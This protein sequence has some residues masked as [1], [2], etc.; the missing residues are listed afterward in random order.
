MEKVFY[1]P[2]ESGIYMSVLFK[3][4][5]FY[6]SL[7]LLSIASFISVCRGI[8]KCTGF[9]PNLT[10][11]DINISGKKICGILTECSLEG[12]SG[13]V[14]YSI[15]GIG[16]NANNSFFP[17]NI[18]DKTTSLKLELGK[19]VKRTELIGEIINEMEKL[20]CGR[21]YISERKNI[22]EEYIKR[23]SLLNKKVEIKFPEKKIIGKVAGIN[24]LGGL[25][26]L[27][28]NGKKEI[29]Y[30]GELSHI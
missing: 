10:W 19:E 7:K 5:I 26:I 15:V 23:L 2:K 24:D 30:T 28:E 13:R 6:D 11:N 1:S 18:K 27:K 21:R 20:I 14:E 8:E 22:L 29:I 25:I 4:N 12:E 3:K 16:I 17:K 9:S